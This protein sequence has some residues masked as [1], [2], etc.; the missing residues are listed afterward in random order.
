[1]DGLTPPTFHSNALS[2]ELHPYNFFPYVFATT[3]GDKFS[4][5]VFVF[6]SY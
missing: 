6:H 2:P 1:M 5:E 4:T 3:Q